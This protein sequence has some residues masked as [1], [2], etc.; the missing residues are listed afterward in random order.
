MS[1]YFNMALVVFSITI[2]I[3]GCEKVGQDKLSKGNDKESEKVSESEFAES[4][5]IK[6]LSDEV[7]TPS[8]SGSSTG[9]MVADKLPPGVNPMAIETI[10]NDVAAGN[11]SFS[12][13]WVYVQG[14]VTNDLTD[15][16]KFLSLETSNNSVIFRVKS[17]V[18]PSQLAQWKKGNSYGFTLFISRI[19]HNL[20]EGI[21]Y[22][23]TYV[24]DPDNI[25]RGRS[26]L[27][28]TK[29]DIIPTSIDALLE[30][31]RK[32][33]SYYIGKRV[34]FMGMVD[35]RTDN[36]GDP[37]DSENPERTFDHIY[38]FPEK[39]KLFSSDRDSISIYPTMQLFEGDLDDKFSVGSFHYFQVTIHYFSGE[40]SFNPDKVSITAYVEEKTFLPE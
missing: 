12:H 31:F 19:Q 37:I 29:S 40:K 20:E 25:A 15:G 7:Y 6:V 13:S 18:K 39:N 23:F 10:V 22:I 2:L 14:L 24:D 33:E 11:T 3:T 9:D 8:P 27:T 1:K 21:R 4:D 34:A 17:F 28:P 26:V 30:S 35:R 32:G 16:N 5:E 36:E 38:I